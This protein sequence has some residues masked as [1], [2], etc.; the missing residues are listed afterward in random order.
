MSLS[1]RTVTPAYAVLGQIT[2]DD[3]KTLKAM[4]YRSLINNRPDGE[5]AGQPLA[6]DLAQAA[7][8]EGLSYVHIPVSGAI[9]PAQVRAM[10]AALAQLPEPVLAFCRSGAR[11]TRLWAHA[12]R[13]GLDD[14]NILTAAAGAGCDVAALA[15][16]LAAAKL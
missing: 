4:G 12:A 3:I 7:L 13:V 16:E 8:A 5:Q 14:T 1:P 2:P 11:S 6:C 15:G 9:T 10:E